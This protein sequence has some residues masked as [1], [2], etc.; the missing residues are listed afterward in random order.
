MHPRDLQNQALVAAGN[1]Q[2]EGFTATAEAFQMLAMICAEEARELLS[3]TN[4]IVWS[5]HRPS[6]SDLHLLESAH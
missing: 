1:A 4:E 6:R 5:A 3:G 2:R